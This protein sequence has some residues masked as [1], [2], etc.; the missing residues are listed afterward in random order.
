MN[1][2]R[3]LLVEDDEGLR[4]GLTEY[5][6]HFGFVV[7]GVPN[8][9]ECF[10][11]LSIQKNGF[12]V[13]IV[14]LGLPDI[15]GMRLVEHIRQYTDTRIIVMTAALPTET[16]ISSYE[17]GADLYLSKPVNSRELVAAVS[18]LATRVSAT[19][20]PGSSPTGW[21]LKRGDWMLQGPNGQ[22][23]KLTGKEYQL[24]CL[25]GQANG[26]VVSRDAL[27]RALYDRH[28]PSAEAALST[29]VKRLRRRLSELSEDNPIHTAHGTGYAFSEDLSSK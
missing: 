19:I 17:A 8:G 27:C 21:I 28:D 18:S 11:T 7:I 20:Q 16:T 22:A 3:V 14:D 9:M 12:Q 29:Q 2:I 5:L 15:D 6:G 10:Q 13:A 26:H 25:L 23:L 4:A 24:L 1:D